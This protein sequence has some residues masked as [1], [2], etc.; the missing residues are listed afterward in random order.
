MKTLAIIGSTGSIGKSALNVY[1]K[2]KKKF[3]LLYLATNSNYQELILQSKIFNPKNIFLL[4][5]N[6]SYNFNHK[7]KVSKIDVFKYKTKI[8]YVISGVSSYDALKINLNLLK[9][10]KN[11]LIANKETIICGG[12]IFLN[13]AKKNKC[14]IVPIDSEHHCIDF[15]LKNFKNKSLISNYTI[16]ASGGPF[17]KKKIKNNQSISSVINHPTWKMGKEISVN[18]SNFSNKV[19]ELF[20]AKILFKIP[21]NKLNIR[22]DPSSKAHAVIKFINNFYLPILHNPNMEISISNSLSLKNN[23][24]LDFK[25]IKLFLLSPNYKKFPLIR[26]G[27]KIL[28]NYGH[29]GMIFFTVINSRL[30]NRYLNNEINYGDITNTLIKTFRKKNIIKLFDKKIYTLKDVYETIKSAEKVII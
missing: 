9:I 5:E 7:K 8:D 19:L 1:K 26:L 25:S 27:F 17:F 6:N 2:N 3:K 29:I 11:L 20:E 13:K 10:S 12:N 4:N 16:V 22:I 21:S 23:F 24:D 18:S 30:V 28:K 15:F 14:N